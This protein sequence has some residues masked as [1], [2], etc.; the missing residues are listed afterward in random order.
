MGRHARRHGRRVMRHDRHSSRSGSGSSSGSRDGDGTWRE[1]VSGGAGGGR[2]IAAAAAAVGG[3][4]VDVGRR[5]RTVVVAGT[6]NG[7]GAG[8]RIVGTV[9]RRTGSDFRGGALSRRGWRRWRRRNESKLER[10]GSSTSVRCLQDRLGALGERHGRR[11]WDL[12]RLLSA[13]GRLG[14]GA[15]DHGTRSRVGSRYR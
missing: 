2:P 10:R 7:T 15:V 11:P 8:A 9:D 6:G 4:V 14:L 12:A 13:L 1:R 3:A 5:N